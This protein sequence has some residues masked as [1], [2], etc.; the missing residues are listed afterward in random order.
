MVPI[1]QEITS[2]EM[3][4]EDH[5]IDMELAMDVKNE[6]DS[7]EI[8]VKEYSIELD[9]EMETSESSNKLLVG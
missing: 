2:P 9:I 5:P 6:V 8:K 7:T 3:S 1:K 4:I